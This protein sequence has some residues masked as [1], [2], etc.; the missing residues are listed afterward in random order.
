MLVTDDC[1][2]ST[3]ACSDGQHC[4]LN[5][6]KAHLPTAKPA[7]SEVKVGLHEVLLDLIMLEGSK[8]ITGGDKQRME[9][10]LFQ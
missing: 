9:V 7:Q 10:I 8:L 6:R 3:A 4:N 2:L 5:G 1:T